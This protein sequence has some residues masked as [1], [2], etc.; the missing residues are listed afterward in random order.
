[1]PSP[2]IISYHDALE[3]IQQQAANESGLLKSETIEITDSLHRVTF[4]DILSPEQ[5]PTFANSAMDGFSVRAFETK[6]A[7]PTTPLKIPILGNLAA[8]DDIP[9]SPN[10]FGTWEIMTG[11]PFPNGFD[12]C[13]RIEDIEVIKDENEI[14]THI[15]ITK[16]ALPNENRR[17]IGE[18]FKSNQVLIP[19]GHRVRA[20]DI[21]CLTSVGVLKIEVLKKPRVGI[22]STGKELVSI[23]T[24]PEPG[25]IRNSSAPFL[26]AWLNTNFCEAIHLGTI[27]DDPESFKKLILTVTSANF[28]LILTTGAIS[29]GKYDFVMTALNEIQTEFFFRKVSMRP[30]KPIIFG[31]LKAGPFIIG[32]PGNPISGAVGLRFFVD[33]FLRTL[34][35]MPV[36]KPLRLPLA[37]AVRKT[38]DATCFFK[39]RIESDS[40]GSRIVLHAQQRP[41]LMHPLLSS[42]IWISMK[43]NQA[44]VS[45]GSLVDVYSF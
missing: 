22:V 34:Q 42:T 15:Q 8:G 36:E 2:S 37:H 30:G 23:H 31:R 25:K 41:S 29:M 21:L 43:Q 4:E 39:G 27:P 38:P 16:P 17:E 28:D 6:L 40:D 20:E 24:K 35:H 7:S 12:A 32:L 9:Q 1:M 18:D 11:A 10:E 33:P 19:R 26:Q 45:A 5:L 44:E 3:V 13:I 14:P